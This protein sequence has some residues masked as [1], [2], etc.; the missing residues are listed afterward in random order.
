MLHTVTSTK[1]LDEIDKGLREAA[2]RHNFGIVATH[3]LVLV[4]NLCSRC[5]LLS[6]GRQVACGPT[7]EI[8]TNIPLLRQ[9]RMAA[10]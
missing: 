9:H 1:P 4:K 8:L 5:I 7:E 10:E 6:G 2:A 3:D